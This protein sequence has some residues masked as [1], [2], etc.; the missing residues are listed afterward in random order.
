MRSA[1]R[2]LSVVGRAAHA[3]T[4]RPPF[5]HATFAI[6][7]LLAEKNARLAEAASHL[8][9]IVREKDARLADAVREKDAH[10]AKAA[11]H[12]ADIVRD[13]D[14]HLAKAAS[15][16]ADI[17]RDKDARIADAVREKNARLAEKDALLA[18]VRASAARDIALAKQVAD[19][20]NG[21]VDARGLLEAC[22]AELAAAL[23]GA[24][25]VRAGIL[26]AT[27][28]ERLSL[29]FSECS[30]F[31]AYLKTAAA[32]NN[33]PADVLL[34][35]AKK[36]YDVLSE[37]VHS[38]AAGGGVVRLPVELF[39]HSGRP[40]LVALAALAR[41]A[42]RDLRLYQFGGGDGGVVLRKPPRI[43]PRAAS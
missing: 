6:R 36:L 35:Q 30:E 32:D 7:S 24:G 8:A 39:Q 12:L 41:F 22:V 19:V 13:K 16:L 43:A 34:R 38:E 11:S 10:L 26:P 29:L 18:T 27:V 42:G 37:R 5:S 17:V 28:S 40:T 1:R 9:D 15:H 4:Q 2:A 20:A 14:A 3:G 21:V 33:V 23:V 31:V 25:R